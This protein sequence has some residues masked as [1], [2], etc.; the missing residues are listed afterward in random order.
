M[1]DEFGAIFE[2]I[3][4]PHTIVMPVLPSNASRW[5]L[6]QPGN[7]LLHDASNT[8]I[9]IASHQPPSTVI[10]APS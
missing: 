2:E 1:I 8:I 9:N 7:N 10:H 4:C 3:S 5:L 6:F